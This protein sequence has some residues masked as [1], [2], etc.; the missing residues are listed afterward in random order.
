M[1][2][3][4]KTA[5]RRFSIFGPAKFI[6]RPRVIA[7]RRARAS[8]SRDS[9]W[10]RRGRSPLP[11]LI[12]ALAIA[13]SLAAL[14]T[15]YKPAPP[16]EVVPLVFPD[17]VAEANAVFPEALPNATRAKSGRLADGRLVPVG[18]SLLVPAHTLDSPSASMDALTRLSAP[19]VGAER[20]ISG[21]EM[22][23]RIRR[24]AE[25]ALPVDV[26]RCYSYSLG[27][28]RS[29][30]RSEARMVRARPLEIA[31]NPGC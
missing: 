6:R 27:D 24:L 1:T 31:F 3:M 10:K 21:L 8:M 9:R 30:S 4:P 17:F 16:A 23:M 11:K 29:V 13:G 12:A 20:S 22:G 25:A 28:T 15:I 14:W 2:M 5:D 26:S 19:F 18:L 7:D